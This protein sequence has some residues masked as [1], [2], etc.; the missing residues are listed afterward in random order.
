MTAVLVVQAI[1][2]TIT[3]FQYRTN[4]TLVRRDDVHIQHETSL[5]NDYLGPAGAFQANHDR[6]Q[7]LI[8]AVLRSE[9]LPI[10]V[11]PATGLSDC[12]GR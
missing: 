8:C 3:L 11:D 12:A 4:A 2:L 7:R 1:V 9:H 5:L 6:T 10:S